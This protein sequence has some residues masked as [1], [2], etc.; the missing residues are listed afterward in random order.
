M[1]A[2]SL[3]GSQLTVGELIVQNGRQSGTRRPLGMPLTLLGRSAG[4][5]L[6]LNVPDVEPLHCLIVQGQTGIMLRDLNSGRGT[7]VNGRR[8]GA[9]ALQDGDLIEVG[10]FRF[11]MH[12]LPV[13]V[14]DW[15]GGEER[16][17]LGIQV[18]AVAAQQAALDEEEFRL[19]QRRSELKQHEEQLAAHLE[20]RRRQLEHGSE[21]NQAERATWLEE[22]AQE[23]R[24]L[25]EQARQ[26][27]ETRAVQARGQQQLLE[28]RARLQS[29]VQ[30]LRQ[31]WQKRRAA[32]NL[33][34]EQETNRLR[35]EE[36]ALGL[37]FD[38]LERREELLERASAR[39]EAERQLA[40]ERLKDGQAGLLTAQLRWRRRRERERA[41]VRLRLQEVVR[42]EQK[43]Q[44]ARALLVQEKE[45]WEAEQRRLGRELHGLNNRV[46]NQRQKIQVQQQELTRLAARLG[47]PGE[48]M[49]S[50]AP[51]G[52]VPTASEWRE[53][54][55]SLERLAGELADQ[56]LLL[57]EQ[58]ERLLRAQE[59][60][61][62]QRARA[63]EEPPSIPFDRAA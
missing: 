62:E 2:T 5:D 14:D 38:E 28:E 1:E 33:K 41:A 39:F 17:A 36:A 30:R 34:V 6:R 10:P 8:V 31:R 50:G 18:A 25:G 40:N 42:A 23:E 61:Q 43:L 52:L 3:H 13:D 21:R 54:S 55:A 26:L 45:A 16:A 29:L 44:Q 49:P 56:R 4:C 15:D 27:A 48:E 51:E 32:Q 35:Q 46:V 9:Q 53:R 22:K 12:L 24:R 19:E 57:V 63:G 60:W 37:H 7:F 47:A 59:A 58:W 20:E 11:R